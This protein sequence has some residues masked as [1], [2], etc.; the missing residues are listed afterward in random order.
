MPDEERPPEEYWHSPDAVSEWFQAVEQKRA[1]KFSGVESV[2]DPD[3]DVD[4]MTGNS[5]ARD[6]LEGG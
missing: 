5:L 1:D 3:D 4:D 2:P 6:M